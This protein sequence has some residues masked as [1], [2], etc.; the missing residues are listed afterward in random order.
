[1]QEEA[2]FF[3]REACELIHMS[4]PNRPFDFYKIGF[5]RELVPLCVDALSHRPLRLGDEHFEDE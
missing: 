3:V 2:T 5:D 4:S 1:M